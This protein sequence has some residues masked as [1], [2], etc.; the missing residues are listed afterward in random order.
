ME[1]ITV[2]SEMK[3]QKLT[4]GKLIEILKALGIQEGDTIC[5][6]SDL[7][8][9]GKY[10]VPKGQYE[11]A[12]VD[13][14]LEVIGD[15]GT[16]IMPTFSYSFCKN[17]VYNVKDTK[18]TVGSLTEYF[19]KLP[20]VTRTLDPIFSFAVC[21]KN[22]EKYLDIGEECFSR[23]SMYGKLVDDKAKMVFLG[24]EKGFTFNHFM[25]ATMQVPYRFMKRFH[26]TIVDGEKEYIVY[27]D[28]YVRHLDRP[29]IPSRTKLKEFLQENE[30][31]KTIRIGSATIS[32]AECD[33][34]FAIASEQYKTNPYYFLES[35]N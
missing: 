12:Y 13:A 11:Q 27:R 7:L 24:A 17:E 9:F 10:K 4:Y 34:W 20:T 30:I 6:H 1:Y 19:R 23:D 3:E 26:G 33:K 21:G 14:L 32:C 2:L 25:E 31:L 29:S 22:K 18:S 5:V 15:E 8:P 28:Y 16:L 35:D